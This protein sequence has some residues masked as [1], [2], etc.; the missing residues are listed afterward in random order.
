[1]S[2]AGNEQPVPKLNV[3]TF[4]IKHFSMNNEWTGVMNCLYDQ[5]QK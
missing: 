4:N 5:V 2:T 1:M 3:A